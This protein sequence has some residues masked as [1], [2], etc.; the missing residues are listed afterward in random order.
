MLQASPMMAAASAFCP[1]V[2]IITTRSALVT[3]STRFLVR[4]A[5][6]L[7]QPSTENRAFWRGALANAEAV[8]NVA[9]RHCDCASSLT[10]SS[11]GLSRAMTF[12]TRACEFGSLIRNLASAA[13][14]MRALSL[15]TRLSRHRRR[16]EL[17]RC[18]RHAFLDNQRFLGGILERL[19]G[20]QH[21]RG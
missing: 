12:T 11:L 21:H 13:E 3:S 17:H 8:K 20:R 19:I 10:T 15:I 9:A 1:G 2:A 4:P 18:V 14:L 16:P 7:S 5:R 6:S